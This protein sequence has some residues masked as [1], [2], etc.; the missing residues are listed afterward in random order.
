MIVVDTSAI[1][2]VLLRQQGWEAYDA[3]IRARPAMLSGLSHGE[4]VEALHASGMQNARPVLDAYLKEAGIEVQR[5]SKKA[6]A[7]AQNVYL[8]YGNLR[9]AGGLN[10]AQSLTFALARTL[11]AP[12][13]Y[14]GE[15]YDHTPAKRVI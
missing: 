9:V 8:R 6:T 13:L 7:S 14:V 2:A 11:K 4:C 15:I 12:L 10:L 5:F 1:F 3:A